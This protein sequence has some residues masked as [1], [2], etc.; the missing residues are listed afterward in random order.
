M[1]VTNPKYDGLMGM[2]DNNATSINSREYLDRL[3]NVVVEKNGKSTKINVKTR[4]HG[5]IIYLFTSIISKRNINN[6]I[7]NSVE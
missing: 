1:S 3:V 6:H 2:F 5:L 4:I 7:P